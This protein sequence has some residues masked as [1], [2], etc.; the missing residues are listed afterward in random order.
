MTSYWPNPRKKHLHSF[1]HLSPE[2]GITDYFLHPERLF[3]LISNTIIFYWFIFLLLWFLLGDPL[4]EFSFSS[5]SIN[6]GIPRNLLSNYPFSLADLIH[7]S[8]TTTTLF[9]QVTIIACLSLGFLRSKSWDK[10][11]NA[12][13]LFWR[14]CQETSLG[15]QR[16]KTVKKQK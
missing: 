13:S 9:T 12:S 10:D 1:L 14:W 15:E 2:F 3:A 6:N 4:T 11:L 16:S 8:I 5:Y 7:F